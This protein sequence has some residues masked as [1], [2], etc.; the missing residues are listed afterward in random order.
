MILTQW[1]KCSVVSDLME[2]SRLQI[3]QEASSSLKVTLN[4]PHNNLKEWQPSAPHKLAHSNRAKDPG[5][6]NRAHKISDGIWSPRTRQQLQSDGASDIHL[7]AGIRLGSS[8]SPSVGGYH[9]R[10]VRS[11]TGGEEAGFDTALCGTL[12]AAL[13]YVIDEMVMHVMLI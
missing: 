10:V 5:F 12:H 11:K 2:G 6:A 8:S 9:H 1:Y 3:T 7:K 4:I 13:C